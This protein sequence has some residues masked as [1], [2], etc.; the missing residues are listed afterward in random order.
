MKISGN[1]QYLLSSSEIGK[2]IFIWKIFMKDGEDKK[3]V[4]KV[5]KKISVEDLDK[6][7]KF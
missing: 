3:Q 2:N 6:E 1:N 7:V 4:P 5:E